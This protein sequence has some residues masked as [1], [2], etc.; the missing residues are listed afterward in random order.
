[1][2]AG[3]L[4]QRYGLRCC[5]QL[6][7]KVRHLVIS[8]GQRINFRPRDSADDLGLGLF[9]IL[10]ALFLIVGL[11]LLVFLHILLIRRRIALLIASFLGIGV[12]LPL[13]GLSFSLGIL[14][15]IMVIVV[16]IAS[17]FEVL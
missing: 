8:G 12:W 7:V 17:S 15:L 6:D 16:A 2:D 3:I 14:I 1:M 10:V 13:F 5:L 11:M 4:V 9:V